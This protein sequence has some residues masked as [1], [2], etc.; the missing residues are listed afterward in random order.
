[1]AGD[2][3]IVGSFALSHT[4]ISAISCTVL[5]LTDA[6]TR[7]LIRLPA[8]CDQVPARTSHVRPLEALARVRKT[9]LLGTAEIA[10]KK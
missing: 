8:S 10:R 5:T 6:A 7:P 2:V 1:V 3:R 4:R 9:C